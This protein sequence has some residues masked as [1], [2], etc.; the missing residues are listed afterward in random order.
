MKNI[1]HMANRYI[2]TWLIGLILL[3]TNLAH[4]QKTM[5]GSPGIDKNGI[6]SAYK[7]HRFHILS[8]S[9]KITNHKWTYKLPLTNGEYETI[10]TSSDTLFQI[11]AIS[12]ED[13]YV[14]TSE[15]YIRGLISFTGLSAGNMVEN[16]YRLT[17]E[18][19]PHILK[20][21]I[22]SI[23]P[24]DYDHTYYDVLLDIYYEGAHYLYVTVEEEHSSVVKTFDSDKPY[25]TQLKLTDIDSWD[26]ALINITVR[27]KYGNDNLQLLIPSDSLVTS[28]NHNEKT[29]DL[30]IK[31]YNSS[32]VF[33]GK[34]ASIDDLKKMD[35][36]LFI[37]KWINQ[38]GLVVK[39]LKCIQ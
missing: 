32:G 2:K 9:T 6:T 16:T 12:D 1:L 14:H 28:I 4:S 29:S 22:V 30:T 27:N 20:A 24:C 10:C 3:T 38:K 18:L 25:Y 13:K 23:T 11:P 34:I 36:G 31:V 21:K 26:N 33:L 15:G 39:T 17:L 19:K 35:H 8:D 5:I 37:L 7:S